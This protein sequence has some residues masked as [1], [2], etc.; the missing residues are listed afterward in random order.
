M[1]SLWAALV[2]PAVLCIA[3][4]SLF[5]VS[6]WSCLTSRHQDSG[7]ICTIRAEWLICLGLIVGLVCGSD[8]VQA[9]PFLQ[10]ISVRR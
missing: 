6:W 8:H 4:Q 3:L 9:H 5:P 10:I 7:L 1:V 2:S